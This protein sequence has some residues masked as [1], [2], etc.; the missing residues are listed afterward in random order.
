[1]MRLRDEGASLPSAAV[2][3]SPWTDLALTGRSLA[4]Y[5]FSDPIVQVEL[6]P[7]AVERSTLALRLSALRRSGGLATDSGSQKLS[8]ER[9]SALAMNAARRTL[10]CCSAGVR[11]WHKADITVGPNHVRF[12]G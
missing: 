7:K 5:S 8:L 9:R 6:M 1:M 3:L 10:F 11:F 4:E 12:G 2:L